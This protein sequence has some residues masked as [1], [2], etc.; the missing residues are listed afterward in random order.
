MLEHLLKE[1]SFELGISALVVG[2][3]VGDGVVVAL[4]RLGSSS[5]VQTTVGHD[6]VPVRAVYC[7]LSMSSPFQVGLSP[8][9]ACRGGDVLKWN[10]LSISLNIYYPHCL[11]TVCLL[12][13]SEHRSLVSTWGCNSGG[14][15]VGSDIGKGGGAYGWYGASMKGGGNWLVKWEVR[16]F[17]C[18]KGSVV[19]MKPWMISGDAG[20]EDIASNLATSN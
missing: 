9:L 19:V 2:V 3:A 8:A 14:N 11:L 13:T 18:G 12:Q 5:S 6:N 1:Y 15:E 4:F 10:L 20:G 16:V 7:P 17:D